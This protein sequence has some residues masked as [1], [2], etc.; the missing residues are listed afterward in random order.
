MKILIIRFSAIGDIVWTSLVVRCCKQQ[1]PAGTEIHFATKFKFRELVE[2][3]PYIDKTFYL[4]DSLSD[5]LKPLKVENYDYVIDLHNNLRSNLCK[6]YLAKKSYTFN[7]LSFKRFLYAKFKMDL[8]PHNVHVADRMLDAVK[9]LGVTN[10][11]KG[12]DF[13]ISQKQEVN[14]SEFPI[15]LQNGYTVFIIGA[16][17]FTKKLPLHKMEELCLK[18]E[19]PII[20]VG[21]KEDQEKGDALVVSLSNKS[22][23]KGIF[24]T[25]GKYSIGQSASIVKQASAVF[26][27]DTGLTHIAAAYHSKI[28]S[29]WGNTVPTFGMYPY[30]KE[31]VFIENK[32]LSCRPCSKLGRPKCPLGHFKCMNDLELNF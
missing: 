18:I 8:M 22:P 25:S 6:L 13:F 28:Y 7:K 31:N 20:L 14:V 23:Q 4:K 9:K 5:L 21:G 1:L 24:N 12:V 15:S 17:Q 16:S 30:A 2:N 3:N 29:I 10:D 32:E 27:H 19:G 11:H 26:G